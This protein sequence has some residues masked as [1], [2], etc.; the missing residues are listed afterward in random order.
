LPVIRRAVDVLNSGNSSL[1]I[2]AMEILAYSGEEAIRTRL[3]TEMAYIGEEELPLKRLLREMLRQKR[4]ELAAL[5]KG[6][7]P[8]VAPL[9]ALAAAEAD[10]VGGEA[11]AFFNDVASWARNG[12]KGAR[13][14]LAAAAALEP[15]RLVRAMS[16]CPDGIFMLEAWTSLPPRDRLRH[17][18]DLESFFAA[19]DATDR[20]AAV[21]LLA[22]LGEA[23]HLRIL[24]MLAFTDKDAA[25]KSAAVSLVRRMT[26]GISSGSAMEASR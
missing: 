12:A 5:F 10:W 26:L 8:M 16:G 25:V 17:S 9:L 1:S 13:A 24:A 22:R 3:L 19:S 14:G 4:G 6:C 2:P 7:S 20:L 18:P 23:R 21:N 15:A 11:D